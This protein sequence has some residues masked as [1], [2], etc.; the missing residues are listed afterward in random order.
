MIQN[1]FIRSCPTEMHIPSCKWHPDRAT[2]NR[3]WE[4]ND[5]WL[6][7][8]IPISPGD[9]S[10]YNGK[11]VLP[12][13]I[14]NYDVPRHLPSYSAN[15]VRASCQVVSIGVPSN[16]GNWKWH[17]ADVAFIYIYTHTHTLGR[18]VAQ[19]VSRWLPIAVARFRVRAACVV[20]GVQ[21]GT[22]AGFFRV[23]RFPLPIIPPIGSWCAQCRVDPI[24]LHPYTIQI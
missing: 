9:A 7:I 18:A 16:L 20:C 19:A 12:A 15:S 21:N 4:K 13:H 22:G 23:L 14:P 24:G 8:I 11:D 1:A 3:P 17:K 5:M 6:E 10:C 2:C